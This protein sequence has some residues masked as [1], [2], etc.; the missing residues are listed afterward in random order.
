MSFYF[1]EEE[2]PG[3]QNMALSTMLGI[4]E[5]FRSHKKLSRF[6]VHIGRHGISLKCTYRW[7]SNAQ[8]LKCQSYDGRVQ[9][10]I[11]LLE[12]ERRSKVQM[13]GYVSG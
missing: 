12:H 6:N 8:P 11:E 10:E 7:I 1:V 9:S 13:L 4:R 5:V 2:R 3:S